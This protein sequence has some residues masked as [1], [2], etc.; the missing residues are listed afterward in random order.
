[1]RSMKALATVVGVAAGVA[2]ATLV[3]SPAQ[4]SSTR[5]D[6][7]GVSVPIVVELFTSEGCSS[8]P[9]AD[10]FLQKLVETQPVAG[11]QIIALGEHVDYWDRQG[12]KDRFASAA[13][14]SRQQ[15][16][17]A[18]FN[19]E[20]VYTPQ[21]IVDG[22]TEFVGS[23]ATA[24]RRALEHA[25]AVPHGSVRI[26][27]DGT[28]ESGGASGARTLAVAV[29]AGDLPRTG[30]DRADVV[31]A[32]TED[33]LR[34]DVTRGENH[35]RVL[36]HAAVVRYLAPVGEAARDAAS[37]VHAEIPIASDWQRSQLTIVA[38]VQERRARTILAA[39]ALPVAA[40]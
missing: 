1:M 15:V 20:S 5:G 26:A 40:R 7:A 4:R 2:A 23:D 16:Y 22:R 13:L 27:F 32:V 30:T 10:A 12:W 35:G 37:T 18:R 31:I 28:S 8:C 6:A 19:T 34:S 39:A 21:M 36:T 11:A 33:R 25:R 14:T 24:A 3:A 9:P 38:F 29:T 17:G